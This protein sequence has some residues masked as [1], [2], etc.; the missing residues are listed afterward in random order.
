MVIEARRIE[1]APPNIELDSA[2]CYLDAIGAALAAVI[3]E[4]GPTLRTP[5]A[6]DPDRARKVL[7]R[8]VDTM[9]GFTL[10][11]IANHL[12]GGLRR[13]Y[14]DDGAAAMRGAL[15][16]WQRIQ[17]EGTVTEQL[18]VQ[19]GHVQAHARVLVAAV[20]VQPMTKV[21]LSL[22]AKEDTIERRVGDE[23]ARGW[24]VYT[25]AVTTRRYPAM[26][27]MWQ[28]WQWQLDGKPV[29]TRDENQQAGY[30]ALVR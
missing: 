9:T 29:L 12:L 25:A 28:A 21:M 24:R 6:P 14:G 27:A 22:L 20:P 15:P 8:F 26:N 23:L 30:I 1:S 11:A 13:W 4:V 16:A 5:R 2:G 7:G 3:R 10:G 17:T 19:F 18:H